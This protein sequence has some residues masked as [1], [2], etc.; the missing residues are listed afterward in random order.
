MNTDYV[1]DS[2]E[3]YSAS[4]TAWKQLAYVPPVPVLPDLVVSSNQ[5]LASGAYRDITVNAGVTATILGS[6]T[7]T[8][9]G[10]VTINGTIQGKGLGLPTQVV[11]AASG[12]G[13]FN[14]VPGSFFADSS[15]SPSVGL[16]SPGG[17]GQFRLDTGDAACGRPGNAGASITIK[18]K[19]AITVGSSGVIDMSGADAGLLNA[20]AANGYSVG[21]SGG[22]AGG[23]V[24][25][26]SDSSIT[27][28]GGSSTTVAGGNGSAGY[29]YGT[30]AGSSASGGSGGG[31]GYIILNAPN[32][33]QSGTTTLTGGSPGGSAGTFP[34]V[35]SGG[36]GGGF[37]GIG[38][39][40]PVTGNPDPGGTGVLA[41]NL[42]IF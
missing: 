1:P 23:L 8:A 17:C 22:G 2:L 36:P 13:Q 11:T 24:Y 32:I 7:L 25:L 20:P 14:F 33:T 35:S 27:L 18:A 21:G 34:W 40:V 29:N 31:G 41:T 30:G 37:A 16:G 12:S 3:V 15:Y 6:A 4:E 9:T 5:N 28:S 19:G 39:A 10:T 38:G 42:Y 26:Q